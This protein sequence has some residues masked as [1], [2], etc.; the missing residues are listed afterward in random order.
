MAE[1]K[2]N[3]LGHT[4]FH[5]YDP[6]HGVQLQLVTAN[7]VTTNWAAGAFGRATSEL[8]PEV[9]EQHHYLNQCDAACA[10]AAT[11]MRLPRSR[12]A[13]TSP[14]STMKSEARPSA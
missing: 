5:Q 11:H 1:T 10:A 3:A 14:M 9:T 13:F 2:K 8:P 6:R 7:L 12:S 4:E